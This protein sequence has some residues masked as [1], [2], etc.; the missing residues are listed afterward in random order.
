MGRTRRTRYNWF[1]VLPSFGGFEDAPGVTF[2]EGNGSW[3]GPSEEYEIQGPDLVPLLPDSTDQT[4]A[5]IENGSLRDLVEGQDYI[6]KRIVG[7]FWAG[8][9]AQAD[10]NEGVFVPRI[11]IGA[12]IAVLPV[13]DDQQT[14]VGP[15]NDYHPLLSDNTQNPWIWRRTW[16]LAVQGTEN[17]YGFPSTTVAYGSI[18]DGGHVDSKVAR[19]VTREQRLFISVGSAALDVA[20]GPGLQTSTYNWGYDFRFLGAMRKARN[21]STFK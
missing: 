20:T 1:P 5:G 6:L 8:F 18:A 11:I 9:R 3:T 12:G 4:G 19:R 13:G 16:I 7:K 21:R 15:S 2:Y 17:L 14:P 10:P